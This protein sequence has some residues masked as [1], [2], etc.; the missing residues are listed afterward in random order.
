MKEYVE[1]LG[2]IHSW[3]VVFGTI[4]EGNASE[5]EIESLW[6]MTASVD[7]THLYRSM[8]S[9]SMSAIASRESYDG[10]VTSECA[11]EIASS[12]LALTASGQGLDAIQ[13]TAASE[14]RFG[15][16]F[17]RPFI[18]LESSM[19]EAWVRLQNLKYVESD[20]GEVGVK[21]SIESLSARFL[22]T[23]AQSFPSAINN[24]LR[25]TE[26]LVRVDSNH[27]SANSRCSRCESHLSLLV[28][29]DSAPLCSIC[30]RLLKA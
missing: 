28:D 10:V 14:I 1:E 13:R 19:I 17:Y 7:R 4:F 18:R 29:R 9:R 11:D 23:L 20:R 5:S 12:V 27:L 6:R 25:T 24:V 2:R 16:T 15:L 30:A 8:L 22:A 26:K 21:D 3:P